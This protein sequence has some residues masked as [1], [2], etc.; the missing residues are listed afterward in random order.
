MKSYNLD[1]L[2][3]IMKQSDSTW[4]VLK[5]F[6]YK[7]EL[8]EYSSIRDKLIP[9]VSVTPEEARTLRRKLRQIIPKDLSEKL[10]QLDPSDLISLK[11]YLL[12]TKLRNI[13]AEYKLL[14]ELK[15]KD[16]PGDVFLWNPQYYRILKDYIETSKQIDIID[17]AVSGNFEKD[18]IDKFIDKL[19]EKGLTQEEEQILLTPLKNYATI[20][21][22][23]QYLEGSDLYKHFFGSKILRDDFLAKNMNL[24]ATIDL[25]EEKY[26]K[27]RLS[28]AKRR[29]AEKYGDIVW[30]IEILLEFDNVFGTQAGRIAMV[31][32]EHIPI[33][34]ELF[35]RIFGYNTS[36]DVYFLEMG[37]KLEQNKTFK[38]G[39]FVYQ[40][41]PVHY[42]QKHI[43][44]SAA[45]INALAVWSDSI[46][47]LNE[48]QL[49][50]M[51]KE[52]YLHSSMYKVLGV[53]YG[54][55][56]IDFLVKYLMDKYG[57]DVVK[58]W[59]TTEEYAYI[60]DESMWRDPNKVLEMLNKYGLL[61]KKVECIKNGM[62]KG[63]KV[64]PDLEFAKAFAEFNLK[65]LEIQKYFRQI[66][67]EVKL[68]IIEDLLSQGYS[69][70]LHHP[71][72]G[73]V[74]HAVIVYGYNRPERRIYIYDQLE[75]RTYS[76]PYDQI[77]EFSRMPAGWTMW[78]F[79][80]TLDSLSYMEWVTNE[81][82]KLI[83]FVYSKIQNGR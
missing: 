63:T 43:C 23:I 39:E 38:E 18:L 54:N 60:E 9:Q 11:F 79:R 25:E 35:N 24:M 44:V 31:E 17:T 56:L 13:L 1:E 32:I 20:D 61:A 15:Q 34:R 4:E 58:L 7:R 76:I 83:S 33:R 80:K 6:G 62:I 12:G 50:E 81:N 45:S 71:L 19:R 5:K 8:E 16:I 51:E 74:Q 36:M 59:K 69:I 55:T 14:E 21:M 77:T 82:K 67:S 26:K 53:P 30:A 68:E 70:I 47:K 10:L 28:I 72:K 73:A 78:G 64:P 27:I 2:L 37:E 29:L 52:L 42:K 48:N 57:L 3:L 49:E 46:R 40:P 75:D 41:I 22:I 66:R 65:A